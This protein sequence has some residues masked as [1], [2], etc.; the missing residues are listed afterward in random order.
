MG[1]SLST[2]SAVRG[3]KTDY[4]F[5]YHAKA[6]PTRPDCSGI[7]SGGVD[8]QG[9]F[10]E[11]FYAKHRWTIRFPSM[12]IAWGAKKLSHPQRSR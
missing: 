12:D 11:Q 4:H 2:A 8:G 3:R 5:R 9:G 1:H 7:V 10:C 6:R